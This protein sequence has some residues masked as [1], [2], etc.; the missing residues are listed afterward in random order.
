MVPYAQKGEGVI[1]KIKIGVI[2]IRR[3]FEVKKL[4]KICHNDILYTTM[5]E[6]ISARGKYFSFTN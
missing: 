6:G 4:T 1:G 2:E 5:E 3:N